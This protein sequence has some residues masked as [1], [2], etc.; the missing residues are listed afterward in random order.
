MTASDLIGIKV[1]VRKYRYIPTGIKREFM[2]FGV[3]AAGRDKLSGFYCM[4]ILMERLI[5]VSPTYEASH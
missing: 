3:K 1:Y 4:F 5:T 2:G